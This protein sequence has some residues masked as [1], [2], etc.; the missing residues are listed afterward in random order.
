MDLVLWLFSN[1]SSLETMMGTS[2]KPRLTSVLDSLLHV[3]Y[4]RGK[5]IWTK[6]FRCALL[7]HICQPALPSWLVQWMIVHPPCSASCALT[8]PSVGQETV[9]W[10]VA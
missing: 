1:K 9:L 4:P 6:G 7:C 10:C 5:R 2:Q 3:P 8:A